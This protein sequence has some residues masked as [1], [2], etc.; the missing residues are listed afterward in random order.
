MRPLTL[1]VVTLAA[2]AL[3]GLVWVV[4]DGRA[5]VFILPLVFGLPF[6]LRRRG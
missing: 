2:L 5:F 1:L 4:S 6:L 3:T